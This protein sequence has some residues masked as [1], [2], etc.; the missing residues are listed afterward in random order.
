VSEQE[1][2]HGTSTVGDA[3]EGETPTPTRSD[4]LRAIL[5]LTDSIDGLRSDVRDERRGR[6][7]SIVLIAIALA[8]GGLYYAN[9]RNN[10]E[11]ARR[12]ACV[13]RVL[14]RSDVRAAIGSAVNEVGR[15]AELTDAERLQLKARVDEAVYKELPP[16]DC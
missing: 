2:F 1:P 14:S 6:R 8:S 7:L 12:D 16:P 10:D 4:E 15:F 13:V 9:D 11:V 3:P 5:G